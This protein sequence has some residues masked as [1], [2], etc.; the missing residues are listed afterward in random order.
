[1]PST[2]LQT[3]I[4]RQRFLYATYLVQCADTVT[5][6]TCEEVMAVIERALAG[7]FDSDINLCSL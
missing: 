3:F 5:L 2:Q 6:L 4:D 1:M 7:E